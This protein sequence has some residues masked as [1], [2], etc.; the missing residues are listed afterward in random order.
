MGQQA[1]LAGTDFAVVPAPILQAQIIG[2]TTVKFWCLI[3]I[4]L[5]KTYTAN[6][7]MTAFTDR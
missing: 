3:G 4:V 2:A 5:P 7:V 1:R 6:F